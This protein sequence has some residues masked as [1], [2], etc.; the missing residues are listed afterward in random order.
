MVRLSILKCLRICNDSWYLAV[1]WIVGDCSCGR[2]GYPGQHLLN[3]FRV[4]ELIDKRIR[5]VTC[6]CL[7]V[8][9][10][11]IRLSGSGR[12][13][14]VFLLPPLLPGLFWNNHKLLKIT[15]GQQALL[16]TCERMIKAWLLGLHRHRQPPSF[17]AARLVDLT[18]SRKVKCAQLYYLWT[19]D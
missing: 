14:P 4:V 19:Y 18:C 17:T 1:N 2:F 16:L 6:H 15:D 9:L 12:L 7:M 10:D 13:D 8:V 3:S 11:D 5:E